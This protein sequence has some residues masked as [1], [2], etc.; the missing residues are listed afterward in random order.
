MT[1]H[2]FA[3][4]DL[5]VSRKGPTSCGKKYV[6][7]NDEILNLHWLT[8]KRDCSSGVRFSSMICVMFNTIYRMLVCDQ[9]KS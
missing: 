6:T 9:S 2:G 3:T 5:R 1:C 8:S 4:L 7:N